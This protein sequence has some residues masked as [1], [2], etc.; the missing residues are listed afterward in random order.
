MNKTKKQLIKELEH[1][2]RQMD[3]QVLAC[4][5]ADSQTLCEYLEVNSE[6][7]KLMIAE[8]ER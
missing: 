6:Y 5:C 1:L 4:G 2:N 8:G 7:Q 3:A